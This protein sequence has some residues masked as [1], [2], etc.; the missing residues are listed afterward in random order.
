[1]S[2]YFPLQ[3]QQTGKVPT[4]VQLFLRLHAK[5]MRKLQA[6][7]E[8]NEIDDEEVSNNTED[9]EGDEG[10]DGEQSDVTSGL[11]YSDPR[12]EHVIVCYYYDIS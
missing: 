5:A 3:T 10:L 6:A 11:Q 7:G 4:P 12:A 9:A 1:M 8:D 2:T